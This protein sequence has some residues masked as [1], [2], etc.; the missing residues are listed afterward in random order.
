MASSVPREPNPSP[1]VPFPVVALVTAA[2]ELDGLAAVV[3]V[4][5]ALPLGLPAALV[6]AKHIQAG[7][8]ERVVHLLGRHTDLTVR[9][10]SHPDKL[11]A[12][13]VLVAPSA[14]QLLVTGDG[15]VGIVRTHAGRPQPPAADLLLITLANSCGPRALAVLMTGQAPDPLAGL[16]A[17]DH[18]GGTVF[19]HDTVRTTRTARTLVQRWLPLADIAPAI[20]GWARDHQP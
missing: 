8:A 19:A 17:I 16:R 11:S 3:R 5:A 20:V 10:A 18:H 13:V 12:G 15:R 14:G 6:V 9:A 7:D 1:A 4:L 2:S